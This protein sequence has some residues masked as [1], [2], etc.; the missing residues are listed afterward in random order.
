MSDWYAVRC[1]FGQVGADDV[2]T[3]QD[4]TYEERITLWQAES[5]EEAIGYAEDEA[6]RHADYADA[7][8]LGSARAYQLAGDPGSGSEVFAVLRASEL[9]PE[10]YVHR[11]V[12]TGRELPPPTR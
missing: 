2:E 10:D 7:V 5:A 8:Y 9:G 12:D 6:R 4:W 1:V 11:F 3:G